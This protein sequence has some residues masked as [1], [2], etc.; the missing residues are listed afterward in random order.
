VPI[1]ERLWFWSRR[2]PWLATLSAGLVL[3]AITGAVLQERALREARQARAAAESLIQ[4]M[5][6]D[7]TEQLRPRGR[8]GLLDNV[9]RVVRQYYS[10]MPMNKTPSDPRLG[11]AQFFRNNAS[12]LREMGRLEEAQDS[13]KSSIDLLEPVVRQKP[14]AAD[15]AVALAEAHAEMCYILASQHSPAAV[16][17]AREAVRYRS[18]AA[19][20]QPTSDEAASELA[21]A[22]LELGSVLRQQKLTSE[23]AKEIELASRLL[24]RLDAT[25]SKDVNRRVPSALRSYYQALVQLDLGENERARAKFAEYLERIQQ[26][27][28]EGDNLA[29]AR[30]LYALAVA[31]SHLGRAML[32]LGDLEG[33]L[34]HFREYHRRA[35]E[36]DRRDPGNVNYRQEYGFSLDWLAMAIERTGGSPDEITGLLKSARDCFNKLARDCPQGDVW[37]DHAARAL[38]RLAVWEGARNQ[39]EARRLLAGEVEHR[40][41][42]LCRQTHRPADHR[43]FTRALDWSEEQGGPPGAA[44]SDR[45]TRLRKWVARAAT[46][47][48]RP[49]ASSEWDWT[50][51]TLQVRLASALAGQ[52]EFDAARRELE[53]ALPLWKR[54]VANRKDDAEAIGGLARTFCGINIAALRGSAGRP[55]TKALHEF[56]AWIKSRQA[57]AV[58]LSETLHWAGILHGRLASPNDQW[59]TDERSA[60]DEL[61]RGMAELKGRVPAQTVSSR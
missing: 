9:N 49:A 13:A 14:D 29:D 56:A 50:R 22:R 27:A 42:L 7:L 30:V 58:G 36:L 55:D 37:Q 18:R 47:A 45:P 8:L 44:D 24:D 51:A 19:E 54:L 59:T 38:T 61:S 3:T 28:A 10:G 34:S 57:N 40:W 25:A 35:A 31:H 33:A 39:A 1:A 53:L 48:S 60:A 41:D 17:H 43:R 26:L 6:E 15:W 16:E 2:N 46:E 23:A 12:V 21:N 11:K 52:D 20:L 4:F 32:D 5:N